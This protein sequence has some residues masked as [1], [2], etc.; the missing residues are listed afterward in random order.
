[1]NRDQI[2]SAELAFESLRAEV[3]VMRRALEGLVDQLGESDVARQTEGIGKGVIRIIERLD[4][5]V[6]ADVMVNPAV[7]HQEMIAARERAFRP[8]Q[9]SLQG[10][11]RELRDA[12][13]WF[14]EAIN[15]VRHDRGQREMLWRVAAAS[16]LA[17]L[18]AFPLLV[19]PLA[20]VL[21]DSWEIPDMLT[22]S[23][24]AATHTATVTEPR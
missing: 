18:L 12:A 20:R 19:L 21:P 4:K 17:G 23:Q 3:I 9:D 7:F 11:S 2:D 13:K 14:H 8:S 16:A 5:I 15:W 6:E 10:A 22:P 24:K 1:M